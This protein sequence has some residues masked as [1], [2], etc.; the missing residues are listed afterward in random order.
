L[1]QNQEQFRWFTAECARRNIQ[2][3]LHFYNI[4]LPDGLAKTLKTVKT[5]SHAGALA[6]T[7]PTPEVARYY[8]YVLARYFEQLESVGLYICPGETLKP[9]H[10][11]EWFR[12]VIFAAARESGKNPLLV[13]RDWT[14]DMEFR[15]KV[16]SLYE[17]C[18]SEL[19][20]NDESFTSPV[21]DRRH[22]QWRGVLKGHVVNLHGPPMDLQPM[23]WGSPVLIHE[24]VGQWRKLGFV[25]GAEI[26]GLSCFDWPITQD[27]LAPDQVGYR[28]QVKGPTLLWI[29]LSAHL[30]CD[31][32]G[33]RER[34]SG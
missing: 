12:D 32:L 25:K 21:P 8:R 20:H 29:L 2:V 27:K 16:P 19:K 34:R 30:V 22:Q 9:A 4:H 7:R 26:Y 6:A 31:I 28:E 10:Q 15:S 23:R 18:Y 11:L 1:R 13:L 3:L 33:F 17:N 24:T 14:M 5:R